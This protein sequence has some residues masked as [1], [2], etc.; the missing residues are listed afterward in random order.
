MYLSKDTFQ[1]VISST[2]L[3][4]IDLIIRNSQGEYLLGYR[5]NKPAQGYWFVP[6]GRILKGEYKRDAFA[7]LVQNELGIALDIT[8]AKFLGVF[9]HFYDDCIFDDA[10]STHY[11]VLGYEIN[12]DIN[13]TEL[14]QDQHSEYKWFSKY[15]LLSSEKV[16]IHSKWYINPELIP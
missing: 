13:L 7:R 5:N 2:P 3:I 6:G 1:T 4:S 9:E 16:H 15:E 11:V 10:I 8:N 14:P 12:L